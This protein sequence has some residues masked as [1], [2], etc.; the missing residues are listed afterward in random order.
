[1]NEPQPQTP[2]PRPGWQPLPEGHLPRPAYFPSGAA[3]GVTFMF[4]GVISSWVIFVIGLALF[5]AAF[6]GWITEIRHERKHP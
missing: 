6:A 1:M 2:P 3:M 5:T 4:W